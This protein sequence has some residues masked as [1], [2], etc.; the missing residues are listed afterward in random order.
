[1]CSL[2]SCTQRHAGVAVDYN[3][4][5]R[6]YFDFHV[7][8][9]ERD[10]ERERER[11]GGGACRCSSLSSLNFQLMHFFDNFSSFLQPCGQHSSV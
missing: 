10:R 2:T 3:K 6:C 8:V 1:M 4:G 7:R 5:P 9:C 11:G